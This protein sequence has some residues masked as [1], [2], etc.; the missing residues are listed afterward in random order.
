MLSTCSAPIPRWLPTPRSSAGGTVP[1]PESRAATQCG[2]A[3]GQGVSELRAGQGRRSGRLQSGWWCLSRAGGRLLV[4][5]RT[6]RL[7]G[8]QLDRGRHAGEEAPAP[9]PDAGPGGLPESPEEQVPVRLWPHHWLSPCWAPPSTPF[10]LQPHLHRPLPRRGD[11]SP[12]PPPFPPSLGVRGA[13]ERRGRITPVAEGG[14]W[15]HG[16]IRTRRTSSSV[17]GGPGVQEGILESK[18]TRD[19]EHQG[20]RRPDNLREVL[21]CPRPPKGPG[22]C[23]EGAARRAS[24]PR[25][26]PRPLSPPPL[27]RYKSCL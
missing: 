10:L 24:R 23:P 15:N 8:Q 9:A 17:P 3:W 27:A 5:L 1:S 20:Q 21:G 13:A 16:H 4:R 18:S 19:S 6:H 26:V 25:S 14:F 2:R 11:L 12:P 7:R 22:P